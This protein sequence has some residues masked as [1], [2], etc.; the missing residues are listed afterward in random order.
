MQFWGFCSDCSSEDI[1]ESADFS[2]RGYVQGLGMLLKVIGPGVNKFF[3][4]EIPNMSD[5][6]C[7]TRSLVAFIVWLLDN[8]QVLIQPYRS[9]EPTLLF[10]DPR[11]PV[12]AASNLVPDQV[13][14]FSDGE[15]GPFGLPSAG[16][17]GGYQTLQSCQQL[18]SSGLQFCLGPSWFSRQSRGCPA[19]ATHSA[20]EFTRDRPP[21]PV[22]ATFADDALSIGASLA[23]C[24]RQQQLPASERRCQI[25]RFS[26]NGSLDT[27]R[28][29]TPSQAVLGWSQTVYAEQLL[30]AHWAYQYCHARCGQQLAA[31]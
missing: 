26:P 27:M 9:R 28:A 30:R 24:A 2:W 15:M 18:R 16:D 8:S 22:Q 6:E 11:G 25:A 21:E 20:A 12:L 10:I 5:P 31:E 7:R 3:I 1:T 13:L 4:E 14:D 29:A 19:S 17:Y 23:G